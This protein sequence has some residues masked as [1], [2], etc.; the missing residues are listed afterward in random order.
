LAYAGLRYGA[1][2]NLCE[3]AVIYPGR[4]TFYYGRKLEHD[5]AFLHRMSFREIGLRVSAEFGRFWSRRSRPGDNARPTRRLGGEEGTSGV[6]DGSK[7][8]PDAFIEADSGLFHLALAEAAA[9]PSY[10]R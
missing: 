7:A 9:N 4:G 2:K 6:M 3:R 1:V 5:P 10:F 8:Y